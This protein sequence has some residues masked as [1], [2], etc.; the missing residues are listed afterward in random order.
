MNNKDAISIYCGNI[1]EFSRRQRI[2]EAQ[3]TG[4][5]NELIETFVK[6]SVRY[7]PSEACADFRELLPASKYED[8]ARLCMALS[9]SSRFGGE[10][11]RK[12]FMGEDIAAGSHGKVA[13]VRNRYNELAFSCFSKVI[14]R[15]KE[16]YSQSFGA[17]CEDVYDSR[18]EFCILPIENS[19]NGRLFGFYSMLDR[20]ELR[21]CAVC[22]PESEEGSLEGS[23]KYALVGRAIPDRVPKNSRWCFEF[24]IISDSG[25]TLSDISAVA[26][27][28]GA[29]LIKIDSLPVE[30]DSGLQKY[31]FTFGLPEASISAFDLFLTEEYARY[32][33]V[34]LYPTV[35]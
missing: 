1:N 34:G 19:R 25:S 3:R 7:I 21:I 22:E 14:T 23:V 13:L 28:F 33:T 2:A 24:S 26:P 8:R 35:G 15:P 31:Y 4:S 20:Y 9:A 32:T 12:S 30:Y 6:G 5:V 27:I 11:W 18:S 10:M 29:R 17:A 16:V